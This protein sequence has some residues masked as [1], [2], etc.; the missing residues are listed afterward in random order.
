MT[1]FSTPET[2]AAIKAA[3]TAAPKGI[4]AELWRDNSY[5]LT[6]QREPDRNDP[7]QEFIDR[8]EAN[9]TKGVP[10][11]VWIKPLAATCVAQVDAICEGRR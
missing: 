6:L 5:L 7:R 8:L 1:R 11:S 9:L 4:Q 3:I 10:M 2:V